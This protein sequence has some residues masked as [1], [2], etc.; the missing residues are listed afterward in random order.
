MGLLEDTLHQAV[1]G[2]VNAGQSSLCLINHAHLGHIATSAGIHCSL[3]C[4]GNA[5][6]S[7]LVVRLHVQCG[8]AAMKLKSDQ[9]SILGIDAKC[10]H[11]LKCKIA[12]LVQLMCLSYQHVSWLHTPSIAAMIL[13]VD[14]V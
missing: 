4:C 14:C 1:T 2:I 12:L 9:Q 5:C 6:L 8:T 10:R 7:T 3:A 11:S 13:R